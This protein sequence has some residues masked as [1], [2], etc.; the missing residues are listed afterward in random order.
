MTIR[1]QV[2]GAIYLDNRWQVEA[3]AP[4]QQALLAALAD[5]AALAIGTWELIEQ[6]RQRSDQLQRQQDEL[7]KLNKQLEAAMERQRLELVELSELAQSQQGEL[8]GRYQFENLVGQSAAMREV[9]RLIGRIKEAQAPAYIYG[10]SGTGKELVAKAIHF[11]GPRREGPFITV[12]CGAL[13]P[14]LLEG[15]LFGFV[16]GAFTGAER[17]HRGLFERANGGS[18]FLDEVGDMSAELQVKLL[19]VLQEKRFTQVGGEQELTS[20]FRL[21]SASNKELGELA[22]EGTFRQDL[23]YRINVISLRLPPLRDRREDIPLLIEHFVRRHGGGAQSTEIDS[24]ALRLLMDYDWPG[25]ARE[26]E[27]EVLRLL[28]LG[29]GTI[30][31]SD[32]SPRIAHRQLAGSGPAALTE[33]VS[34]Q[35]TLRAAVAQLEQAMV[36]AALERNDGSVTEAAKQL[37]MSRV[38]LHKMIK[39]HGIER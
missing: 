36:I 32:L 31:S 12:N 16:R 27:N 9:F 21:I 19:R 10:E 6:N 1:R 22:R 18:L 28:A 8:E 20:D 14:T 15:E 5:Q 33:V 39:R 24:D 29:G 2:R 7:A 4:R 13:P 17:A 30:R 38:G 3:F 37:G 11:S 26:L 23:Y 35:L 25:N 34:E